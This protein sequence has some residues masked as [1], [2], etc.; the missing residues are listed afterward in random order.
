MVPQETCW[1]LIRGALPAARLTFLR[2]LT[3]QQ[4][5]YVLHVVRPKGKPTARIQEIDSH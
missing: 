3:K 1:T 4:S 2:P 5:L